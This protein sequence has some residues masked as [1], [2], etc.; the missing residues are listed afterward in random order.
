VAFI[1]EANR[2][3]KEML[4][5]LQDDEVF[6]G[7]TCN[8]DEVVTGADHETRDELRKLQQTI[9]SKLDAILGLA[10][11]SKEVPFDL[12]ATGTVKTYLDLE[13]KATADESTQI[14]W[15]LHDPDKNSQLKPSA[16]SRKATFRAVLP[17]E[18]TVLAYTAVDGKA[19]DPKIC[20]ITVTVPSRKG[21]QADP[22]G[23]PQPT[24]SEPFNP[25]PMTDCPLLLQSPPCYKVEYPRGS[26]PRIIRR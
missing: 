4:A 25:A 19:T 9:G 13:I 17:G 22:G 10:K 23:I 6:F 26:T 11:A 18:Y 7:L 3:N 15:F 21:A 12:P 24:P 16:D 20:T 1:I 5:M 14:T 8:V 2:S